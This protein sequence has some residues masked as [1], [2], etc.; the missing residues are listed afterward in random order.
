MGLPHMVNAATHY[1]VCSGLSQAHK[2]F[3][4]L[5]SQNCEANC[6]IL[7]CAHPWDQLQ[8]PDYRSV[9]TLG[10]KQ[11]T[12]WIKSDALIS[13]LVRSASSSTYPCMGLAV[14]QPNIP[15]TLMVHVRVSRGEPL[16]GCPYPL[17]IEYT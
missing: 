15:W 7:N 1:V 3:I 16:L 14:D 2:S 13:N 9:I 6:M 11:Y 5:K 10:V 12:A 4:I 17:Y 8:C